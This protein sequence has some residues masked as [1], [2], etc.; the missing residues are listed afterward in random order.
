MSNIKL[1]NRL[2]FAVVIISVAL[3]SCG[4]AQTATPAIGGIV[5]GTV[6]GDMNGNGTIDAGEVVLGG[7]EV[8]LADCGTVQTQVTGGDGLFNFNNLP[9]GTCHVIVAKAGWIFSGSYPST[10]Y[11]VPV[12]SNPALPTYFSV[13]LAPIG[14]AIPSDTPTLPGPTITSTQPGP[15]D[16]PTLISSPTSSAPMITPKSD[17]ANC[18]LGPEV[19]FIAVGGLNFGVT[20]PITGTLADK[21]WWQIENPQGPG[22]FC[23]VSASVTNTFGDLSTVP[24]K[25]IPTAQVTAVVVTTPAVIHGI[26]G[27]PN[28]TTF[29]VTITTNGPVTVHWHF[30]IFDSLGTLLNKTSDQLLDFAAAGSQTYMSD[31]YKRDCGSYVV[32]AITTSPNAMTGEASWKVVQP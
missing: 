4:P 6:Y 3:V 23:W 17:A 11:P 13:Y 9:A 26:C 14:G 10:T 1:L 21:S 24:N 12:A 2:L 31:A 30:E 15:T 32:K 22:T 27:G 18:R 28:A 29:N 20:V 8:T 5:Q 16:T 25:P 7:V 19:G